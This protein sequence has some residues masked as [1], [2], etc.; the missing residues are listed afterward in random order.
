[1]SSTSIGSS[2]RNEPSLVLSGKTVTVERIGVFD[3]R[4]G[5]NYIRTIIYSFSSDEEAKEYYYKNKDPDVKSKP[6]KDC[7]VTTVSKKQKNKSSFTGTYLLM[8]FLLVYIAV[9]VT[10]N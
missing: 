2:S 9:V 1:M 8:I 4:T 5:S 7:I 6:D 3:G 10:I